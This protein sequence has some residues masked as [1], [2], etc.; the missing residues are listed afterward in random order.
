[1]H[2]LRFREWL[3][4]LELDNNTNRSFSKAGTIDEIIEAVYYKMKWW[5]SKELE[6]KTPLKF[7]FNYEIH[8]DYEYKKWRL[9]DQFYTLV[10]ANTTNEEI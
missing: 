7:S 2:S 10:Y 5:L 8:W 6:Y 4:R 9:E 1:M 3:I